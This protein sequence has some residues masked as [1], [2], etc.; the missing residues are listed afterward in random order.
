MDYDALWALGPNADNNR[1][2]KGASA[3]ITRLDAVSGRR[4]RVPPWTITKAVSYLKDFD[5]MTQFGMALI[6]ILNKMGNRE[7]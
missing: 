6:Q 5:G 2:H 1:H 4:R 7:E 3:A